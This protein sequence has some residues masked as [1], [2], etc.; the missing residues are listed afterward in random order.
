M[1]KPAKSPFELEAWTHFASQDLTLDQMGHYIHCRE[2]GSSPTLALMFATQQG[3]GLVTDNTFMHGHCNGNQFEK[4][5]WR[6]DYYRQVAKKAGFNITGK[7][8]KPSLADFPGDPKAWV[9]GRGDVTRV[10]EERGWN[11]EGS[12]NVKGRKPGDFERKPVG[13]ADDIVDAE[14]QQIIEST[15]EPIKDVGELRD[16]VRN[17]RKPHWAK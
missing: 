16:K 3:P 4:T 2:E 11:V 8:Y 15:P 7:V 1:T 13:V 6:G 17:K 9:S 14:V 12:V 10:A 5:P